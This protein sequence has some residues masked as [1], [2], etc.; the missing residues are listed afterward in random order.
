MNLAPG[1]E[2]ALSLWISRTYLPSSN[3]HAR[4]CLHT[5][6]FFDRPGLFFA[7]AFGTDR[8]LVALKMFWS[9]L[10]A[11]WAFAGLAATQGSD[12]DEPMLRGG[13]RRGSGSM[14]RFG[15]S[16]VVIERLDPCVLA[17]PPSNSLEMEL[18]VLDLSILR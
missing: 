7:C 2:I 13:R 8:Y 14:L 1:E 3:S 15:C 9:G 5:Y 4:P 6:V 18:I 16:Q 17:L 10:V 11:L 12:L